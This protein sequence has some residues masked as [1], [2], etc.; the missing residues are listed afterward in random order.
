V[1]E[2]NGD[3]YCAEHSQQVRLTDDIHHNSIAVHERYDHPTRRVTYLPTF[4]YD[5]LVPEVNTG[6]DT[7]LI[8][9]MTDVQDI[10]GFRRW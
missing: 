1:L 7:Q 10:T 5:H 2:V 3:D 6:L 4:E 9:K 8:G